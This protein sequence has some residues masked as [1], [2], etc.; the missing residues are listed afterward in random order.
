MPNS[1]RWEPNSAAVEWGDVPARRPPEL[2][3]SS[4]TWILNGG[5]VPPDGTPALPDVPLGKLP[6]VLPCECPISGTGLANDVRRVRL[7]PS[8]AK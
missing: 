7:Q 5:D 1:I 3:P 4:N 8:H 6:T 2:R